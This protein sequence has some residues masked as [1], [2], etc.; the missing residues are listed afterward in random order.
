MKADDLMDLMIK[1]A[2]AEV[3]KRHADWS[4]GQVTGVAEKI[5]YGALRYYMLRFS[6]NSVIAFEQ[7][8]ALSRRGRD[9]AVSDVCSGAHPQHL[10]QSG[11]DAGNG[12]TRQRS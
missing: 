6:R 11:N 9:R 3:V 2:K 7:D 1:A 10:P 4:E 12:V 5:A 8:M